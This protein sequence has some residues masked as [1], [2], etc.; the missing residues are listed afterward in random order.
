MKAEAST[1][2]AWLAAWRGHVLSAGFPELDRWLPAD[3]ALG[4]GYRRVMA[5]IWAGTAWRRYAGPAP[6]RHAL[7]AAAAADGSQ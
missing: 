2:D 6:L 5:A 4:A 1:L 7:R 3:P